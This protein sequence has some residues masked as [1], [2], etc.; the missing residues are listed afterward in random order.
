M[1]PYLLVCKCF[2]NSFPF[3][4]KVGMG[5]RTV[6][7]VI[8]HLPP[9]HPPREGREYE[10]QYGHCLAQDRRYSSATFKGA[11]RLQSAPRL[12]EAGYLQMKNPP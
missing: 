4:G 7:P 1:R 10:N 12:H 6:E 9:P 3:R 8:L 11:L 5:A 2:S